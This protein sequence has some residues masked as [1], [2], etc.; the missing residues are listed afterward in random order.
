MSHAGS[1]TQPL[2]ISPSLEKHSRPLEEF[3]SLLS[4]AMMDSLASQGVHTLFPVQCQVIP[5]LLAHRPHMLGHP[6][7]VCVN[8]P[9]GS[10]KTLCYAVPIVEVRTCSSR[11]GL[12]KSSLRSDDCVT[13]RRIMRSP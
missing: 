7:D 12:P 13:R 3:R 10:G 1:L 4:T 11:A 6:S 8:A 5:H 9:T 2:L